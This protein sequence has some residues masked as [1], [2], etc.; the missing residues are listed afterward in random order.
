MVC[1]HQLLGDPNDTPCLK[2]GGVLVDHLKRL[3]FTKKKK[4]KERM[5]KRKKKKKEKKRKKEKRKKKKEKKKKERKKTCRR[6]CVP[7]NL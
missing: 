4:K 2:R 6:E 5:K 7:K 1:C 3:P